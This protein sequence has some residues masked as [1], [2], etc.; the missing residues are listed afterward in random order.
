ML[1]KMLSEDKQNLKKSRI[2]T[3]FLDAAKEIIIN[4]GVENVSVRKIADSAGYSYATIYNYFSD[5]NDLLRL[6]RGVMINDLVKELHISMEHFS[7]DIEGLKKIFQKYMAYFFENPNAFRFF[8][9]TPIKNTENKQEQMEGGPDFNEMWKMTFMEL[10]QEGKLKEED[11]ENLAK[12]LIY[13]MHGMLTLSFSG[14]GALTQ[15]EVNR[16]LEKIIDYLLL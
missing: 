13:I 10:I 4:E 1:K 15:E 5:L 12:T 16:D 8:F 11:M 3:Y 2:V 7:H 6:V 9:L 14:N